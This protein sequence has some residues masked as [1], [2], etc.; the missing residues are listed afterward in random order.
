MLIQRVD[1]TSF[2]NLSIAAS[3]FFALIST[4]IL[5]TSGTVR[6]IFSISTAKFFLKKEIN[7][8]Y[9]KTFS[10]YQGFRKKKKMIP[11]ARN[12][13]APVTKKFLALR[14]LTMPI[15][16]CNSTKEVACPPKGTKS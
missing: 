10:Y 11:F 7:V 14:N 4:K 13:V 12:P 5:P 2:F 9:N 3:S 1:N 8:N 15:P 6:K 16:S